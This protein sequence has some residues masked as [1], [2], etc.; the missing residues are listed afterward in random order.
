M[1]Q[2]VIKTHPSAVIEENGYYK[3]NYDML[4]L[5]MKKIN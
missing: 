2:E 5:T 4:G 1:A 3:V